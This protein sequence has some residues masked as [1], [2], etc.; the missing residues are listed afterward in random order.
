MRHGSAAGRKSQRGA[1]AH[2]EEAA[3]TP[4]G[5]YGGR[6]RW[7]QALLRSS[8][9]HLRKASRFSGF[10]RGWDA[11]ADDRCVIPKT[12]RKFVAAADQVSCERLAI[13]V[14]AP[15]RIGSNPGELLDTLTQATGRWP[16]LLTPEQEARLTFLGAAN[17]SLGRGE[18]AV[19]CDI[20]GGSTEVSVG[21]LGGPL[22]V[23][24][25]FDVGSVRLAEKHF[26]HDPPTADEVETARA[27]AARMVR[28]TS[29]P[30]ARVALTTGG[31]AHTLA[32]LG[33]PLLDAAA[34]DPGDHTRHQTQASEAVARAFAGR[35]CLAGSFCWNASIA[36]WEC[37]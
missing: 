26:M 16:V 9:H 17:G 19:V 32:K 18:R 4:P 37:R 36:A 3:G 5:R 10:G 14:T 35:H 7:V 6:K 20:G 11:A 34:L 33:E 23:I 12:A 27:D 2:T 31:C 13:V 24:G 30:G 8:S 21:S 22:E 25:S 15:G 1:S 28:I 29:Q